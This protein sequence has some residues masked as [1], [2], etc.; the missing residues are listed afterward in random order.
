MKIAIIGMGSIGQRHYANLRRLGYANVR[1]WDIDPSRGDPVDWDWKPDVVLVCTPPDNHTEVALQALDMECK[2]LFIE[3]PLSTQYEVEEELLVHRSQECSYQPPVVAM[4]ACNWRFR[5]GM[6]DLLFRSGSLQMWA[7]IPIPEE[8]RTIPLWDI[9]IHLIDLG[10]WSG[11]KDYTA[12]F[13][14]AESYAV[15]IRCGAQERVWR[16]SNNAMYL[17]EMRHFMRCVKAG[18]PTGNDFH[19]AAETLKLA[20]GAREWR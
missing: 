12:T 3:K 13:S 8:R 4:V 10:E 5:E 14:Y 18:E 17:D 20:L 6:R 19:Q 7:T 11:R 2:G 15:G 1:G 9:G 16:K